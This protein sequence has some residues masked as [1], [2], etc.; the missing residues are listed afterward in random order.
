MNLAEK[1]ALSV[2]QMAGDESG[3]VP[4]RSRKVVLGVLRVA[5]RG[6][7]G[8]LGEIRIAPHGQAGS[9]KEC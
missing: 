1:N 7:A 5:P 4:G 8:R 6:Q 9:S 2:G 3:K